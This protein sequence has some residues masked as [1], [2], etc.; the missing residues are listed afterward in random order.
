MLFCTIKL[1]QMLQKTRAIALHTIKYGDT[2]IVAYVFSE[3]FG[4]QS[5]LIKGAYNKK[6][7]VKANLF[8]PLNLLELEVYSKGGNELQKVKEAANTPAYIN[9]P[10]N[11][12]KNAIVLFLAEVLYRTIKEEAPNQPSFSYVFNS[13]QLLDLETD[14][15]E[16]FHL[17]FLFQLMKYIGFYPLSNHSSQNK[18]F[19]MVNGL[20]CAEPPIHGHFLHPDTSI[21]FAQ[22]MNLN[23]SNSGQLNISG[24]NRR[25]ILDYLLEFYK[26]QISGMGNIRS[27]QILHEVF[28]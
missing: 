14:N 11:P 28:Q 24:Y 6:S 2:S 19:D 8:Y 16:N 27:L 21:V 20:F 23:Y 10:I 1:I 26:M 9:I 18:Y 3:K 25:T 22:L 7:T 5:Y 12:V 17:I 13:L 4:R 15:P